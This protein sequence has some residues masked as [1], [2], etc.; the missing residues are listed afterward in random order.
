MSSRDRF[1]EGKRGAMRGEERGAV[2]NDTLLQ[3]KDLV[4]R[5]RVPGSKYRPTFIRPVNGVTFSMQ[6]GEI[7]GIVGESGSGKTTLGR[8]IVRMVSPTS[9]E[10][11]LRGRDVTRLGRRQLSGYWREVQ[12]MFQDVYASF[13]P[14]FTVGQQLRYVVNKHRDQHRQDVDVELDRLLGV[15]GLTPPDV[16]RRKLP[17]ELSGGQRQRVALVRALAV[18]PKLLVADEPVSML[19]VSL[20]ADVLNLILNLR[21]EFGL[22]YLFI[23]HDLPSARAVCDRILVMYGGRVVEIA[24]ADDLLD[25]P[26]HPYTQRLISAADFAEDS[27]LQTAPPAEDAGQVMAELLESYKGCPFR[28]KCPLAMDICETVDPA[29]RAVSPTHSV[30]CHAVDDAVASEARGSLQ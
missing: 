4:V 3:V 5:F 21:D 7:V 9:G 12:M 24:F 6:Q 15:T 19:D 29:F 13:N 2:G 28:R 17:H 11:R 22:S 30:A 10:I 27:G 20:R 16:F 18:M 26:L 8:T 25:Q 14:V 23:T 1:G